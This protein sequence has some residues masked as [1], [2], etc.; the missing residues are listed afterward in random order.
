MKTTIQAAVEFVCVDLATR[1]NRSFPLPK[2]GHLPKHY[3]FIAISQCNFDNK[4]RI[5]VSRRWLDLDKK[6]DKK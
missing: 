5:Y 4:I 1:G 6:R 3:Q 2:N